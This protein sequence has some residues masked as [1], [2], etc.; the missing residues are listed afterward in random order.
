LL[1]P[2]CLF[3]KKTK[4]V[5][6]I[7]LLI[8][9]LHSVKTFLFCKNQHSIKNIKGTVTYSCTNFHVYVCVIS[10]RVKYICL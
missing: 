8:K 9:Y 1:L 10:I 6:V 2:N 4:R 3:L 7:L 5:T